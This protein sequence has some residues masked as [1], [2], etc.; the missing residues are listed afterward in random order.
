MIDLIR[1]PKLRQIARDLH[2]PESE[3]AMRD[4]RDH[5]IETV[6]AMLREWTLESIEDLRRLVADRL[7]VKLEF[8]RTDA[9]VA[10]LASEYQHF[11]LRFRR[12]LQKE[13]IT[14]DTEGLLIDNP[15]PDKGGRRYLAIIDARGARAPRA[16]FTAWHELAHLLL[17][18]PKQ[19]LFEGFRRSPTDTLKRKDPLESAVDQIAGLL[20]FWEPIF[21]PALCDASAGGLSFGAI[22]T[23][24]D[25]VAPGA[26]L[27]AASLAAIRLWEGPAIFLTAEEATK[28]DGTG[29]ALRVQTIIPNDL[30]KSANPR[31]RKCMRVPPESSLYQTFK[32]NVGSERVTSENQE[33]WEVSGY[34]N[35]PSLRWEVQSLRRGPAVYGLLKPLLRPQVEPYCGRLFVGKN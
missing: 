8:V 18:P 35:L 9:D 21:K 2:I 3:D 10:R 28:T 30:A 12:L 5:A 7:S 31:I 22:E 6:R 16:Y 29:Y 1:H 23:A 32:A 33:I 17:C 14:G 13:F 15:S 27:Y 19:M 25:I 20:A 34:G 4:L 24:S 26:S 11:F